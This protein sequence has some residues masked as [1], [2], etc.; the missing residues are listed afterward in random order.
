MLK[1][2]RSRLKRLLLNTS[3]VAATEFALMLPF[4]AAMYFGAIEISLLVHADRRVT[5]STSAMADL[6]AR[7]QEITICDVED[8]FAASRQLVEGNDMG[9]L[10]MRLTSITQNG[11]GN[12]EVAWS[13]A[14]N[15][16]AYF[17]GDLIDLPAGIMP[18]N[19]SLVMAELSYDYQALL[20]YHLP[21]S[22][23]L[24]ESYFLRPRNSEDVE[25]V[26]PETMPASG[27]CD[28]GAPQAQ[29][30]VTS[31]GNRPPPPPEEDGDS[32]DNGNGGSDNNGGNS[33]NNGGNQGGGGNN[34]GGAD[35][36][37]GNDGGSQ[38]GG[39]SGND[40]NQGNNGSGKNNQDGKK[41]GS[42]NADKKKKKNKDKKK[43]NKNNKDKKKNKNKN[44]KG[45]N[46][47]GKNN[48]GKNNGGNSSN[49]GGSSN[50]NN[51]GSNSG[52]G[53]SFFGWW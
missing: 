51:G 50:N 41:S 43:K 32:T 27:Q 34:N 13:Q 26:G 31:A 21:E 46:N 35:G 3:G 23:Q 28:W 30:L 36:N 4:M 39:N 7:L 53:P 11:A 29:W 22:M 20:G 15:M 6:T 47:N 18:Q 37:N 12:A 40:G 49:G 33:N 10:A 5:N 2:S 38:S 14:R 1:R 9:A 24:G 45:K 52:G 8:I 25:W 48:N 17:N 44:K 19:G 42:G 16:D